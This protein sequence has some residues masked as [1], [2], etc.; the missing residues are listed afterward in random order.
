[1]APVRMIFGGGGRLRGEDCSIISERVKRRHFSIYQ[2]VGSQWAQVRFL[3]I[4]G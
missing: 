4:D 2:L 3:V 1:L